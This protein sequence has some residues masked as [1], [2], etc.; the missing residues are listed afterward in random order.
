MGKFDIFGSDKNQ[1]FSEEGFSVDTDFADS[2]P[3]EEPLDEPDSVSKQ[4]VEWVEVL[5]IAI[6][7]VV[8]IF[9]LV[10]RVATISGDSM[11]NTLIHN[12]KVI[13]TNL[14]YEPKQGDI[15]V[16][17]RNAENSLE[18]Q[19]LS[20][21]PIIKRVIAVGGQTVNIDFE[22]GIVYV[23]GVALKEDY[24]LAPTVDRG[25]VQFPLYIPEG[26]IFVLGDN[27]PESLD[28][29]YS[30]IGVGGIIDERYVL[31][32]AVFR[33]FPFNKIGRLD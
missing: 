30:Q 19:N 20:N 29:R 18:A 4:V 11:K 3:N 25:D 12:D 15:V 17:S 27:R 24:I 1:S 31:G 23:D 13:I 16:I 5:S 33:I 22:Q 28:S 6:I 26:S 8:I 7:A 32:H 14:G 10:F 21:E 9:C 2:L